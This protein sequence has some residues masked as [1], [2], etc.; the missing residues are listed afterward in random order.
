MV[1]PPFWTSKYLSECGEKSWNLFY[2]RNKDHFFR[3]R[4]WLGTEFAE[5]SGEGEGHFLLEIGCGVGNLL[6]PLLRE[7][8][9][10]RCYGVEISTEAVKLIMESPEYERFAHRLWVA[11]FDFATDI[12]QGQLA[13]GLPMHKN[14]DINCNF[15]MQGLCLDASPAPTWKN[16][17][18]LLDTT[19]MHPSFT[20]ATLVFM[21]SAVPPASHNLVVRNAFEVSLSALNPS[22]SGQVVCSSSAIMQLMIWHSSALKRTEKLTNILLYGRMGRFPSSF[23]QVGLHALLFMFPIIT[24]DSG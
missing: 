7:F 14:Q 18:S 21:L 10:L 11:A 2:R 1:I 17:Y 9:L 3:D 24:R 6:F 13:L 15:G 19:K 8:P 23:L 16:F 12:S 22:S 20:L 5:L 4:H